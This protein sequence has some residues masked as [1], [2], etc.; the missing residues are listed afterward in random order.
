[1]P[2][3][4]YYCEVAKQNK[5]KVQQANSDD[6]MQVETSIFALS[7]KDPPCSIPAELDTSFCKLDLVFPLF[8]INIYR[9][10][11]TNLA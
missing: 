4:R 9:W 1:M 6:V 10:D 5:S 7:L 8:P 11:I 2:D 3:Y